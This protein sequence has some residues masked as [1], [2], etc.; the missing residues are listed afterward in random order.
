MT[1][2]IFL[3]ILVINVQF[4]TLL[5][6]YKRGVLD[7]KPKKVGHLTWQTTVDHGKLEKVWGDPN[8]L[9][10]QDSFWHPGLPLKV[11]WN[12]ALYFEK[13]YSVIIVH[14]V[15]YNMQKTRRCVE[16]AKRAILAVEITTCNAYLEDT[17]TC[18]YRTGIHNRVDAT[19]ILTALTS[20][21][22]VLGSLPRS[23]AILH[24]IYKK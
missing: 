2:E 18:V 24:R 14:N 20:H 17:L 21:Q 19:C 9:T 16:A 15:Q 10:P 8:L 13:G 11:I 23:G 12:S 4:N 1:V 6:A 5:R 7:Q 22:F 3:F